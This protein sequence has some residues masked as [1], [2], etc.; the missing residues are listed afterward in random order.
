M[1]RKKRPD[2]EGAADARHVGKK[3]RGRPLK[4]W[5]KDI[6]DKRIKDI[7]FPKDPDASVGVQANAKNSPR[8]RGRKAPE[9]RLMPRAFAEVDSVEETRALLDFVE[10]CRE[11][12]TLLWIPDFAHSR[13]YTMGTLAALAKSS[14]MFGEA[15]LLAKEVQESI[16]VRLGLTN[17][18][19]PYLTKFYLSARCGWKA[20]EQGGMVK[21]LESLAKIL[22]AVNGSSRRE[23]L[24][25]PPKQLALG[26]GAC[27]VARE[28][29]GQVVADAEL[30]HDTGQGGPEGSVSDE[31]G[32]EEVF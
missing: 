19:N 27:V 20:E 21:G 29:G 26:S 15:Y 32:A 24:V 9:H 14:N 7:G 16:I 31:P 12:M 30:V 18:L 23:A 1:P 8:D 4:S 22:E 6:N 2:A 10:E 17:K 25:V 3:A 28:V 13:R 11:N 5:E